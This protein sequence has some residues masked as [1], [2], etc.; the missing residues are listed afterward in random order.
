MCREPFVIIPMCHKLKN[1]MRT[2]ATVIIIYYPEMTTLPKFRLTWVDN[3]FAIY[4]IER[5]NTIR[6]LSFAVISV[7]SGI[8]L[9]MGANIGTSV[10]NTIVSLGQSAKR[11]R[12]SG[13][14]LYD[15]VIVKCKP[16]YSLVFIVFSG[17]L[18]GRPS[19]TSLI[20]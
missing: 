8:P 9:I 15:T 4:M 3:S 20:C 6:I 2:T 1:Y 10:T 11:E 19:M 13:S 5:K 16:R 17:R 14:K 12:S 7:R 18:P